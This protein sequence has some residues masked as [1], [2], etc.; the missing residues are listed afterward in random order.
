MMRMLR[1][2]FVAG[3]VLGFAMSLAG[4]NQPEEPQRETAVAPKEVFIVREQAAPIMKSAF[5]TVESPDAV[6]ARARIGGVL[7]RLLVDEGSEVKKGQLIAV[8]LDESLAG[9]AASPRAQAA[10]L[11]AQAVQ[12]E[13][14]VARYGALHAKGFYPTQAL[15]VARAQAKA[16]REQAAALDAEA[17]AVAAVAAQGQV[18]APVSGRVLS[19][20][21]TE[22]ANIMPGEAVAQIGS[23]FMLRVKLPERHG[24][25]LRPGASVMVEGADGARTQAVVSRVYPALADGRIEADVAAP[26]LT[27]RVYGQR[28]RVWVP[29][30]TGPA[31][32]VPERLIEARYGLDFVKV[33]GKGGAETVVVRR[34][35]P[36]PTAQTPDGVE[37]LA[38]LKPGDRIVR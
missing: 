29:A 12:A 31:L 23:T 30:E 25:A 13:A 15:E 5:A 18:I 4:C 9:K 38:G 35:E 17:G 21:L 1:A 14:D 19:A 32:I 16:L 20:P 24:G 22:G 27:A 6:A 37:I 8:V 7:Q 2:P 11:R 3:A 26:G 36:R 28:V 33:L 10:A 34:G